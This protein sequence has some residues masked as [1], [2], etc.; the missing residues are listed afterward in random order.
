MLLLADR[1][2]ALAMECERAEGPSWA[3]AELSVA[4][5]HPDGDR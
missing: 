5:G 3:A 4:R 2:D 1:F